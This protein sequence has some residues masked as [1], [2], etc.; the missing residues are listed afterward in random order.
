M[1]AS[2]Y[3]AKLSGAA[4]AAKATRSRGFPPLPVAFLFQTEE[5][6]NGEQSVSTALVACERPSVL[7]GLASDVVAREC[8]ERR[9]EFF[10]L[11]REREAIRR[12]RLA[13]DPA[14][15]TDDPI[16]SQWMFCNAHRENDKTTAWFR[17]HV[18]SKLDGWR[19]IE[20]TIAFRWFNLIATG[21]LVEDL[22]LD[23]W[24]REEAQRRLSGVADGHL[25][26]GA[27]R[28]RGDTGRRKLD[29]I[30]DAIELARGNLRGPSQRWG[31]SLRGAWLD[32]CDQHLL[33]PLMSYEVVSDLRWTPVLADASDI[34]TWASVGVGCFNGLS[35]ITTGTV[36]DSDQSPGEVPRLVQPMRDLLE[37]SRDPAYWPTEYEPWEMRE[38]E[39]WLCETAK[40][41]KAS[42]G[43]SLK[44]RFRAAPTARQG[45]LF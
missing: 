25:W 14:P 43:H 9:R 41:I 26:S 4:I 16:W 29:S 13:G 6:S 34:N 11:A 2:S 33:G 27:Y 31:G 37:L 20:A 35:W 21:E 39:H 32:L 38:V 3:D 1:N 28:I 24:D 22:L 45:T 40:Y 5:K 18:R 36:G 10:R 42:Q 44:R 12:R 23:G 19:V 30:L 17:E 7:L 15:W 8:E